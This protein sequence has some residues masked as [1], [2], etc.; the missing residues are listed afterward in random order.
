SFPN[1][2]VLVKHFGELQVLSRSVRIRAGSFPDVR[3][4]LELFCMPLREPLLV[5]DGR[6][7]HLLRRLEIDACRGQ[8]ASELLNRK[9][10]QSGSPLG[11]SPHG[12]FEC[13]E[14]PVRLA[15]EVPESPPVEGALRSFDLP[16]GRSL[17]ALRRSAPLLGFGEFL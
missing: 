17:G 4:R 2:Q 15:D 12:G 3:P 5:C 14:K 8:P 6:S 1:L 9:V 7:D 13:C 11:G 16:F 10:A